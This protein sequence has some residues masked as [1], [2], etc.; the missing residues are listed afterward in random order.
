MQKNE[1]L[2]VANDLQ[3]LK[4]WY[5][6]Y[7]LEDNGDSRVTL[8]L[9]TKWVITLFILSKEHALDILVGKPLPPWITN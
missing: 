3:N 4:F 8:H 5:V 6:T 9:K 2:K 1:K 7:R